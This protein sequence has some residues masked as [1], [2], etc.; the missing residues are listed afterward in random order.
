MPRFAATCHRQVR[1]SSWIHPSYPMWASLN[2]TS[3]IRA[4]AMYP[5]QGTT[6]SALI[7][8]VLRV[9]YVHCDP[10]LQAAASSCCHRG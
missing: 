8:G 3:M 1:V 9:V 2:T 4:L 10:S 7:A 5:V 6:A